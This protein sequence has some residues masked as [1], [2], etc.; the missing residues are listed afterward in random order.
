MSQNVELFRRAAD[1]FNDGD[2]DAFLAY[3]DAEVVAS[4]RMAPI[5]GVFRGHDGVRLWFETLR[6]TFPDFHSER[7]T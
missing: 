2:R 3:F 6:G 4:P 7:S 1:A 5:E